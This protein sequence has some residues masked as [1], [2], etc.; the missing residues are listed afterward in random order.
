MV[1]NRRP[2]TTRS[3]A[4]FEKATGNEFD[5]LDHD[6]SFAAGV[7]EQELQQFWD[8][9]DER[10]D[11][12]T[13]TEDDSTKKRYKAYRQWLRGKSLFKQNKVDPEYKSGT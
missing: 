4:Y 5:D 10:Q 12:L 1:G 7:S 6:E 11:P 8:F 3:R 9:L 2:Q 13:V